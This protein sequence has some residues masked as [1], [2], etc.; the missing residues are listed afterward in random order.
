[1]PIEITMPRLSDTMESGHRRQ[2]ERQRGRRRSPPVTCIADIETDKATMELPVVRRRHDREARGRRGRQAVDVGTMIAVTRRGRRGRE[3]A[4][5]ARSSAERIAAATTTPAAG[6]GERRRRHAEQWH[7]GRRAL[8]APTAAADR[9]PTA[10][11]VRMATSDVAR[12]LAEGARQGTST[13]SRLR[14]AGTASSSATFSR[15]SRRRV[16]TAAAVAA[17]RPAAVQHRA[18]VT[19]VAARDAGPAPP[20]VAQPMPR[21]RRVSADSC[22]SR[23][24]GRRSRSRL[25][26]SK[27]T[28]PHYQVSGDVRDGRR[29][30]SSVSVAQR[31]AREARGRQALRQRL[32]RAG[33]RRSRCTEH[34]DFNASWVQR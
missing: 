22:R 29:S 4:A 31:A 28:I 27:T 32:P 13:R 9:P 26:E 6:G 19:P 3:E 10:D 25:V 21:S 7:R 17:V 1:M 11:A 18:P 14:P 24:C 16:E 23:T 2:V 8:P 33:V 20:S 15:P 5:D 12:N 34:P 30:W